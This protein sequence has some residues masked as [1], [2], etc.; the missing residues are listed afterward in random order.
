MISYP[1]TRQNR[2]TLA[3]AFAQVPRVDI[4]IQ[5]VLEDQMGAAFVDDDAAPQFFMIELDGFF[6]YLAGDFTGDPG[7]DFL[8]QV[9]G[10]RMLMAGTAGWHDVVGQVYGER[11]V[12]IERYSFSSENLI[13]QNLEQIAAINPHTQQVQQ[14]DVALAEGD[15]PYFE[16]GAFESAADFVARGAG[17]CMLEE[18]KII[19]VAYSSLACSDAIEIS[20]FVE[21]AYRQQGR[22]TAL[23]TQLLLWCLD[24]N[25][26]PNWDAANEESCILAEKLGFSERQPYTAYFLKPN[27]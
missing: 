19:A 16:I 7:A 20:I 14:M 2:I 1:L 15:F 4:S 13:R 22:A 6:I 23:A 27:D 11:L 24:N 12:T 26:R 21:E 3:R 10:G 8:V 25:V 9:P 18:E 5:C 17:F